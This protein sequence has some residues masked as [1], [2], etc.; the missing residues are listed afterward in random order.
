MKGNR[1]KASPPFSLS[2]I[3]NE[4]HKYLPTHLN[5]P[6]KYLDTAVLWVIIWLIIYP[7]DENS[8]FIRNF[9]NGAHPHDYIVALPRRHEL[10]SFNFITVF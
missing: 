6:K 10:Y 3:G 8:L 2:F 1:Q 5:A 9:D 4:S 7:E